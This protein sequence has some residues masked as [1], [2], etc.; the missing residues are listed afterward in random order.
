[1]YLGPVYKLK[2]YVGE[3]TDDLQ[4]GCNSCMTFPLETLPAGDPIAGVVYLRIVLSPEEASRIYMISLFL[5]RDYSGKV[6][7][8]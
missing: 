7:M 1:V 6:I 3:V 5:E 8:W 4:N 2:T